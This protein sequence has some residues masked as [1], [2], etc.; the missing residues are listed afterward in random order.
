MAKDP[1]LVVFQLTGGN[2]Y[3]NTVIPRNNPLYRDYRKLVVIP[4]G[5]EIPIDDD[6][7]FHPEMAPIK[8]FW[9]EGPYSRDRIRELPKVSLP[10]HG[11]L[12]H[13]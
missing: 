6:Y 7:G 3:L 12:A 1:V 8:P 4:E 2:D 13:L 9:D 11:Y 10:L 5:E